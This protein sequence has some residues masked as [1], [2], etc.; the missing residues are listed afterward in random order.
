MTGEWIDLLFTIDF[1]EFPRFVTV[2]EQD[3]LEN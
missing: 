2:P 3:D 1:G